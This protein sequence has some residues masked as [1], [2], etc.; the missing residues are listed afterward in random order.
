MTER[1][2]CIVPGCR[3]SSAVWAG[4]PYICALHW[5]GVSKA[6]KR[7][8]RRTAREANAL[9]NGPMSTYKLWAAAHARF[10]ENWAECEREAIERAAGL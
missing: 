10:K 9:C 3:N 7:E 4:W 2:V 6:T 8:H 1:A 5:R